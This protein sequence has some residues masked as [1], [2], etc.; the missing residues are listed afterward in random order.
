MLKTIIIK[1]EGIILND[2]YLHFKYYDLLWF[3]LR[4]YPGWENFQKIIMLRELLISKARDENPYLT[5]ARQHLTAREYQN[6]LYEIRLFNRKYYASYLRMIPGMRELIR[7]L[8]YYYNTAAFSYKKYLMQI[9]VDRFWLKDYVRYFRT[10]AASENTS[11]ISHIYNSL[12][13]ETRSRPEE[14]VLIANRLDTE[15]ALANEMGLITIQAVFN[16]RVRG[17]M[18][19]GDR[20]RIFFRSLEKY[21][22]YKQKP[23]RHGEVPDIVANMPQ[24]ISRQIQNLEGKKEGVKEEEKKISLWD[25]ARDVLLPE[26]ETEEE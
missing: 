10:G 18:P 3:H 5:I 19:Q 20:E 6:Y 15:I 17:V 13:Q 22:G 9:A 26:F 23:T 24:D 25:I 16:S 2:D 12:L 14:T 7:S 1:L 21:P 4:R 11:V 8:K